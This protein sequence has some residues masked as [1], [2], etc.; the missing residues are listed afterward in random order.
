MELIRNNKKY[1]IVIA[2]FALIALFFIGT[3]FSLFFPSTP[4][5]A[6][7]P[8]PL[9]TDA[10]APTITN[11]EFYD[12]YNDTYKKSVKEIQQE[13]KTIHERNL[14]VGRFLD[15]LPYTGTA[16]SIRY[17]I[18]T[19]SV[20]VTIPSARRAEGEN[21]LTTYL[22]SFEIEDRSWIQNLSVQYQ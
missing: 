6:P 5:P 20:T 3:A 7:S 9:P 21:E 11:T 8:T 1:L 19:N 18:R 16:V 12:P 15:S 14:A 17:D 13:E 4:S 10:P 2:V 22:R